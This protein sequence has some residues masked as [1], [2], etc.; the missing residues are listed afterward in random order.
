M[1]GNDPRQNNRLLLS[2]T[3]SIFDDDKLIDTNNLPVKL[4]ND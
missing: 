4:I 2:I 1:N 3:N